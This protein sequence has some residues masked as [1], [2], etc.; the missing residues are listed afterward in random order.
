MQMWGTRGAAVVAVL[1]GLA[2]LAGGA[3]A[4]LS[5]GAVS[6]ASPL[7]AAPA[8]PDVGAGAPDVQ[9]SADAGTHPA[10]A[11]VRSQLQIHFDAINAR[12]YAG[13]VSTVVL[14]R[15]AALPEADWQAA[16]G[17]TTDGTIRIDRID[18]LEGGRVLV[19]VRF[20]S[21][22]A[23]ADAPDGVPAERVCWRSALPMGGEPPLIE[24]TGGGSS[25]PTAC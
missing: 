9:L 5:T 21:T 24:Q 4:C 15:S 12:D 8:V 16:Y 6:S 13:W 25:V 1:L 17:T 23:V 11:A 3:V 10:A 22:Q 19:L 18:D 2:L 20:V 7:R 14:A